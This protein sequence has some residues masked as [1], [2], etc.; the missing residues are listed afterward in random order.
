M[1]K[2]LTT[3][4]LAV[5]G[6]ALCATT[7][8]ATQSRLNA[9]G[10]GSLAGAAKNI[11][12]LDDRNVFALPAELVK[13]GNWAGLEIGGPGHTS[14][15]FHYRL[16]ADAIL[17]AYGTNEVKSA[18]TLD[19]INQAGSANS[20]VDSGL[21]GLTHK[22]TLMFPM[23]MGASRFGVL[24]GVH[25]DSDKA[26]D[27]TG[28]VTKNDG[29]LVIEFGLG[30]GF[31]VGS[32]DLDIGLGVRYGAPTH[33]D[34]DGG[35]SEN[36]EF[37]INLLTRLTMPFDGGRHDLVPYLNFAFQSAS[38]QQK[39][40]GAP[41]HS[42]SNIIVAAGTDVRLKFGDNITMQP[43][44]G[45][46]FST[47]THETNADGVI[48]TDTNNMI[49]APYYNLSVEVRCYD[50]LDIRF[51]GG[52]S[53]VFNSSESVTDGNNNGTDTANSEVEHHI[54]TGVGFN[55][56]HQFHIDVQVDTGFWK[57]GP[58]ILTGNTNNFGVNAAL[59]KKF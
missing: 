45:L 41:S 19:G 5:F 26:F 29:P 57:N 17:A 23:N 33:E 27:D 46:A 52:Q 1:S 7:A 31:E 42:G 34:V 14:F 58:H 2:R 37:G 43:G 24:L 59:S 6:V 35:V 54:A 12:I 49:M 56:P 9:L 47:Y 15:G 28:A 50:W 13:Y 53:V 39:V 25:A 48:S 22:G 8:S 51:G 18:V 16:N 30:A 3:I 36:S 20:A 38:G 40:E 4:V 32:A 21:G 11:T 55:L 44:V 10:A